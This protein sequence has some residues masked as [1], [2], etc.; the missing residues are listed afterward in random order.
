M[1]SK[2][3]R[4]MRKLK[5]SSVVGGILCVIFIPI[6]IVNC[7]LLFASFKHPDEMPGVFGIKPVIVL[8]GSMEP[9]IKTGDMIFLH[10]AD[11]VKLQEGDV[12]CYL[13]SGKAVTHRI[14]GILAGEDGEMRY[15]TKG[16]AN[17]A[18]DRVAVTAD[19]LEGIWKGGRIPGAGRLILFMQSSIGMLVFIICPLLLFLLWDIWKRRSLDRAEAARTA[20][21]QAELEAELEALK[22]QKKEME[23]EKSQSLN[24]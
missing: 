12:I 11:P 14:A 4:R 21:L 13:S 3:K 18:E 7:L 6:I 9:A 19:Q 17:N 24:S 20:E 5:L 23:K 15:V 16:D 22:A 2:K 1:E 8:S 10:K